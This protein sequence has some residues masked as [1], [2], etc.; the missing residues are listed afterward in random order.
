[1]AGAFPRLESQRFDALNTVVPAPRLV[2]RSRFGEVKHTMF[3]QIRAFR[4][5][6]H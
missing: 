2:D 5:R 3:S 1:M 6:R 4:V